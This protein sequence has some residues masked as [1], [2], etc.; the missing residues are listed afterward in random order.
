[1]QAWQRRH[2]VRLRLAP[3][4]APP[5]SALLPD[6]TEQVSWKQREREDRY[7]HVGQQQTIPVEVKRLQ[8]VGKPLTT[9]V[10]NSPVSVQG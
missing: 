2:R 6:I 5:P 3:P 8:H 4:P 1:M 9:P 10:S 7:E